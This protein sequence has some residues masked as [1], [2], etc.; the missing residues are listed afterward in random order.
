MPKF[1][2]DENMENLPVVG[3]SFNFSAIRPE[4]LMGT[5]EYTL[6]T[7]VTD[8]SGSVI[9]YAKELLDAIKTAVTSCKASP[10]A[11]NL[12]V[13]LV[14][15]STNVTEVHGFVKLNDIIT[16][17]Y[18]AIQ[19]GG[20]TSLFD[21]TYESIGATLGYAKKLYTQDFDVNGIV[22][23]IT[24]GS[25]NCS[26]MTATGVGSLLDKV[27]MDE[28]IESLITILIGV[29]AGSYRRSL[30]DF[31]DLANLSQ[32]V[33]VGDANEK[34]LAKFAKF[35]SKSVSSQ[36]QSLGTGGPSQLLTF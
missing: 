30:E 20:G 9:P 13:R 23:I 33:D 19:C 34:N 15:F 4:K 28:E 5:S 10:R 12:L 8:R 24:D 11:E 27:V 1:I 29:N 35:V 6:V 16:D 25:D 32:Y 7:I 31:K 14:T 3:S 17:D 18:E 22:F 26:T 36:S 2:N 21:A